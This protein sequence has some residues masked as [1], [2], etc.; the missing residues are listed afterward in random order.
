VS[1]SCKGKAATCCQEGDEP[2]LT[3][4]FAQGLGI[5]RAGRQG[6]IR[7]SSI[8]LSLRADSEGWSFWGDPGMDLPTGGDEPPPRDPVSDGP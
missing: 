7:L 3:P 5:S 6:W 4:T 1:D 2:A 8:R